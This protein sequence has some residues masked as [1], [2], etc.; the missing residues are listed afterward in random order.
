MSSESDD[1]QVRLLSSVIDEFLGGFPP[2]TTTRRTFLNG[3]FDAGLAWV[4]F[5]VGRGGLG[6]SSHLQHTV[7]ERLS[8]VGAPTDRQKGV[9]FSMIAPTIMS[10][11]DERQ[12]ERHLRPIFNEDERW[13]QLFSEPGA[14]SD[15]AGLTTRAVRDG[16]EWILNGQKV[17]TS[18][19]NVSDLGATLARTDSGVPKHQGLTYFA[20][21]M[22]APGIEVR[23]LRQITGQA[24]FNEVFLTDVRVPDASRL[25]PVGSGWKVALSTLMNERIM[26]TS[27]GR[28][29]G[30]IALALKLYQ[31]RGPL[32]PELRDR[33]VTLWI[34]SRILQLSSARAADNR[35]AGTPGPEG[36]TFKIG[37]ARV[38]Q[39]GYELCLELLGDEALL[40]DSYAMEEFT[41]DRFTE[42][43]TADA[44]TRFLRS[45]A[46]S[47]EGGTTEIMRN[48]LAE[49]VLGLP[50]EHRIDKDVPFSQVPRS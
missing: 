7:Y 10:W 42:P 47:I 43:P 28:D 32:G 40:Y 25:G 39:E 2:A 12:M 34:E 27:D 38:S 8:N 24:E 29:E 46:T 22:R 14:G 3:Q 13:C 16:D 11:G 15:L 41:A 6:I 45:R 35:A 1:S 30:P 48:I 9:G 36:S 21:D 44:Q 4:H 18:L 26:Y 20:L 19:A 37:Y 31:E 5:P 49:R 33:M 17:W 50:V 23:P